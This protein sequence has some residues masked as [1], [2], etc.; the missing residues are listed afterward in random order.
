MPSAASPGTAVKA[1]A[2][3]PE[4]TAARRPPRRKDGIIQWRPPGLDAHVFAY[5]DKLSLAQLLCLAYGHTWPLLIPGRGRPKGWRAALLPDRDSVFRIT[6]ECT[7][8]DAG[9]GC[10]TLRTSDTTSNGI[11]RD[12]ETTRQYRYDN[13]VWEVRPE[14]SRLTRV[15]ITDYITWRMAK[16]G[17]LF[18]APEQDEG[19]LQ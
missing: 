11:L 13:D 5:L 19:G 10:G 2:A 18:T 7:R 3:E 8:D 9:F 17:E 15:D 16:A 1:K 14:G 6:E 4:V 12:R